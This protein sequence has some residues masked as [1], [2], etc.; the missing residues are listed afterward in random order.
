MGA[1]RTVAA[2][3]AVNFLIQ[4]VVWSVLSILAILA[5]SCHFTPKNDLTDMSFTAMAKIYFSDSSCWSGGVEIKKL[6]LTSA[7]EKITII[8]LQFVFNFLLSIVSFVLVFVIPRSSSHAFLLWMYKLIFIWIG[9]AILDLVAAT[10]LSNDKAAIS[11]GTTS[12]PEANGLMNMLLISSLVAARGYLY[13]CINFLLMMYILIACTMRLYKACKKLDEGK[14]ES[15][16]E[17]RVNPA[18][19]AHGSTFSW[20]SRHPTF[21]RGPPVRRL[22]WPNHPY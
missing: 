3:A 14:H 9:T 5:Y 16:D 4:G 15:N 1:L 13:W 22:H 18:F 10:A 20:H 19:D 11:S 7:T 17:G 2:I 8:S 12:I 6:G 21:H